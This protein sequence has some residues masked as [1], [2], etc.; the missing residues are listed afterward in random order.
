MPRPL[1]STGIT[2]LPCYYGPLRLPDRKSATYF[3]AALLV[4]F[5]PEPTAGLSQPAQ[6]NFPCALSPLYPG[7]LR[8]CS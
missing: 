2:P 6:P 5:F 3:F 7:E 4:P 8:R 1:G